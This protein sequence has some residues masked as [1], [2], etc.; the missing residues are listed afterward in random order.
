LGN[1]TITDVSR[2]GSLHSFDKSHNESTKERALLTPDELMRLQEGQSVVIR[3]NKRQDV[4]RRKIEPKPI[5]NKNQTK[6]KFRFEYLAHEFD[7]G[8]SILSLP[9]D[10]DIYDEMNL[11]EMVYTAKTHDDLYLRMA[12]VMEKNQFKRLKRNVMQVEGITNKKVLQKQMKEMDQWSFLHLL[13]YLVYRSKIE[14]LHL[15]LIEPLH[16]YL[17][18]ETIASWEEVIHEKI[19]QHL[20]ERKQQITSEQADEEEIDEEDALIKKATKAN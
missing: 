4:K 6:Q 8:K 9:I 15:K 17:P 7:T 16:Q 2:T 5:F 13:S 11:N 3:V 20:E 18:K 1:R 14:A 19:E 12:E 10:S